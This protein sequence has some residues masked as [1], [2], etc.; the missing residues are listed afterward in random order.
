KQPVKERGGKIE[1][2]FPDEGKGVSR[3]KIEEK[4][5]VSMPLFA[6]GFKDQDITDGGNRLLEKLVANEIILDM[7]AGTSSDIYSYLYEK[8]LIDSSFSTEYTGERN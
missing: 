4:L 2:I 3:R 1:R 7:L 8:G 5:A 6:L